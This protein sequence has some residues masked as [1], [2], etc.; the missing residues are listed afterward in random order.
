[1]RKHLVHPNV[2]PLL[3]VTVAPFQ[4]VSVWMTG[5]DLSEYIDAHPSADRLGLVGFHRTTPEDV[6]THSPDI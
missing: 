1:M 6:L 3:G 5:G 4:H 2:V